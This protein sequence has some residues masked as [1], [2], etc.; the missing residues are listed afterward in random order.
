MYAHG[1]DQVLAQKFNFYSPIS[2]RE[3]VFFFL[4][5]LIWVRESIGELGSILQASIATS[6]YLAAGPARIVRA[7]VAKVFTVFFA[8][9]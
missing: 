3:T 8:F 5:L 1:Q 6:T 9:L 7:S 4:L 2:I